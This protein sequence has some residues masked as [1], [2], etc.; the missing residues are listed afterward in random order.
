MENQTQLKYNS[1]QST[2]E[3]WE[4][5]RKL[6]H[7]SLTPIKPATRNNNTKAI[8][9]NK[10]YE[11]ATGIAKNKIPGTNTW[12]TKTHEGNFTN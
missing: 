4:N 2:G 9:E 12:E 10:W 7:D 11:H 5:A 6:L 8:W 3:N 1:E